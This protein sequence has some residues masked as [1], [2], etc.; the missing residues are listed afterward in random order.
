MPAGRR[1]SVNLNKV[2]LLRNSRHAGVPDILHFA[3]LAREAGADGTTVHP[4]P[5]E[6]HIRRGDVL[7]LAE[8]MKPWRPSF[9]LNVE[10]YPDAR[11]LD[12]VQAVRP[13]Q[14]TL[15][16]MLPTRSPRRRVGP[17]ATGIP[18]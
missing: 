7:A 1:L 18:H 12:I 14:C 8:L 13:E 2:A 10:G 6:R 17:S 3:T 4:R 9:E 5:D 16:R 15:F 11:L